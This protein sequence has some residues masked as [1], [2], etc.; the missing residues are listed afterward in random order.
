[1]TVIGVLVLVLILVM[2]LVLVVSSASPPPPLE[3][4]ASIRL[5]APVK[6]SVMATTAPFSPVFI[7]I[8]S[9]VPLVV[10]RRVV[11]E[12]AATTPTPSATATP[13]PT[14]VFPFWAMNIPPIPDTPVKTPV[15]WT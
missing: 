10:G 15:R 9:P 14:S 2:V 8:R 7:S 5:S 4:I 11:V 13:S 1:M 12:S 3:T 6:F